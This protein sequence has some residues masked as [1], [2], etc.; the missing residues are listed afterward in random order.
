[1]SILDRKEFLFKILIIGD[2]GVGRRSF[3]RMS[4]D[5]KWFDEASAH[6]ETVGVGVYRKELHTENNN[7]SLNIWNISNKESFRTLLASYINGSDG[8]LL[9]CDITNSSSLE[10]LSDY[11][12]IVRKKAGEIPI[13]LVGN[14]ID[15]KL[16]REVSLE[17]GETFARENNLLG[18]TEIS[19]RRGKDF[20]RVF[21]ILVEKI[22]TQFQIQQ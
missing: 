4:T 20:E 2:K 15:L 18:Y 10:F 19:V 22:L 3:L 9:M 6:I 7:I 14:K 13:L 11:P 8:V 1:M 12:R 21:K 5:D 16:K 17:E